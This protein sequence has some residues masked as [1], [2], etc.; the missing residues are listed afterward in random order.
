MTRVERSAPDSSRFDWLGRLVTG[1]RM[2]WVVVAF[3]LAVV[4]ATLPL[5][6]RIGE[7]E[8]NGTR[9]FLPG[10]AESLEVLDL[11]E[12]FASTGST[13][14]IIVFQ[15]EGGLTDEDR[16]LVQANAGELAAASESFRVVDPIP[17]EDGNAMLL[18]V[19]LPDTSD[20]QVTDDVGTIRDIVSA[21]TPVGLQAKVTGPAGIGTD[22]GAVFEGINGRLL[23]SA[24]I[25]VAV[26]LL[27]TYR[28]PF[29]WIVPLLV[30][31]FADRLANAVVF[32]GADTFG[33]GTSGQSVGIMAILVFG[34]GTDYALL[35]I[36]RY[37]EE[38]RLEESEATAMRIAIRQAAPAI[39]ASGGTVILGLA[40][41]LAA[42]LNS[43]RYLAPVGVA[44]IFCALLL[45]LTL[46]PAIL[47]IVTRRVFWP[48]VPK[49]GSDTGDGRSIWSKLGAWVARNPRPI[50]IGSTVLLLAISLGAT[51]Y[52]VSFTQNDQFTNKPEAIEGAELL[53]QSFPAGSGAPTIVIGN[54]AQTEALQEAI[55][56]VEGVASVDPSG[57]TDDLVEFTVTLD[58]DPGSDAAF[59]V[60][61]DLRSTVLAVPDANALV[62]GSDAQSLDT[63]EA[64]RH[65]QLIVIPLVLAVVFV[66]LAVLLRSLLAPVL[67]LLSSILS[68]LAALGVTVFV[69]QFLLGYDGL[70]AG[71]LL[72]G[73]VFLTALGVD[74]NI[75]LMSRVHEESPHIGTRPGMLRALTVTG[76]VITSA[77]IVLAATF[78]VLGILP[79]VALAQVGFLVSFGVLLDALWVRS[80]LVPAIVL[81]L[82][83]RI[84][85]PSGLSKKDGTAEGE[86]A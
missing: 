73:F 25:V 50:W 2:R 78:A 21:D 30:V 76:G 45:T 56:S 24:A 69:F 35:L 44:G 22:L 3:W 84:W 51:Q 83:K 39:L 57:E 80:V 6:N 28:S 26:L 59:D 8:D 36:A 54:R 27:I 79:L 48:F 71:V 18:T 77:G 11:Q 17:S 41:L 23:V 86:A 9:A 34:A 65:D 40:C 72:L 64:N 46:L 67:L 68:T 61:R 49:Y 55:Q 33:F 62:G 66:V 20:D 31:G 10:S 38:L 16:T 7:V 14:A 13:T 1:R 32:V 42:D 81:D 63:S 12:Q 70:Q 29:L 5:A 85:W 53:A 74:Y 60:I 52:N 15:R 47:V 75:F 19:I 4:F 58:T 82:G 37:R 43:N